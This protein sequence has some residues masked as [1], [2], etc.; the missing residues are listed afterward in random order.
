MANEIKAVYATGA[1]LDFSVYYDN[2]GTLTAR[3]EN[4]SMDEEPAGSGVYHGTPAAI[5]QGDIIVI[6][7]GATIIGSAE[8]YPDTNVVEVGGTSQTANDNGADINA[9]LLDTGT[10]GVVIADDAITSAKYDESTAFPVKSADTGAT[11]IARV[12]ADGDTLEDLSDEI[13]GIATA[14]GQPALGG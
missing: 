2:A 1:T 14:A 7:E 11:Q 13:A 9:I 6:E 10:N 5:S 4:Q 12:G 8:Y 3:E